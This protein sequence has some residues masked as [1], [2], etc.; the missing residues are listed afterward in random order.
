M[1]EMVNKL[2]KILKGK[3]LDCMIITDSLNRRYI[4]GFT[5]SN[6]ILLITQNKKILVTDFRY[7]EQAKSEAEKF[8]VIESKDFNE[9]IERILINEKLKSIGF[10][11]DHITVSNFNRLKA[12]LKIFKLIPIINIIER[13]RAIKEEKE[14]EY[15]KKSIGI[16]LNSLNLILKLVKPGVMERDLE[17]ELEYQIKKHGAQKCAFDL[18]IASGERSALPHGIASN[19]KLKNREFV[20]FDIGANYLGYNSD[21][22]RT[23]YLGTIGAKEKKIY[24]IVYQAR[25]KAIS[26]IRAGIETNVVDFAGRDFI[27]KYGYGKFFGHGLGHGLGLSVHELPLINLKK[28]EFLK[29]NMVV[30]IEP[31]I[32]IPHFGGVRIEDVAIVKKDNCKLLSSAPDKLISL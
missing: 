32:Y 29:E 8:K 14:I 3:K 2:R 21:L 26:K 24:N 13:L 30:T 15:I 28:G 20:I 22:T 19:K 10:E 18:I 6:G 7:K 12:K 1:V 31:G 11:A 9:T 27:K 5:G 4:S 25:E 17:I 23:F 16:T